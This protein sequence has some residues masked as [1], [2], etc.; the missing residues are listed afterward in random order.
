[1]TLTEYKT[2]HKL[3]DADLAERVGIAR[4]HITNIRNGT[5]H[6]SGD[7]VLKIIKKLKGVTAEGIYAPFS[8][9]EAAE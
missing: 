7:L 3:T 2:R 4:V 8:S 5:R 9:S 1:M 6:P